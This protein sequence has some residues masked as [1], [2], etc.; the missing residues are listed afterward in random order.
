MKI[1][2]YE[3]K[4]YYDCAEC[5]DAA[6]YVKYGCDIRT[7]FAN[8][9]NF[10]HIKELNDSVLETQIQTEYR[11]D[12][13]LYDYSGLEF[14]EVTPAEK[15]MDFVEDLLESN[16]ILGVYFNNY[17]CNWSKYYKRLNKDHMILLIGIDRHKQ[18]LQVYDKYLSDELK[19]ITWREFSLGAHSFK[20]Y[21]KS[22]DKINIAPQKILK[23]SYALITEVA[24]K[25]AII[26]REQKLRNFFRWIEQIN[27]KTGNLEMIDASTF[28]LSLTYIWWSRLCY[29]DFWQWMKQFEPVDQIIDNLNRCS[30]L[31]LLFRNNI[32]KSLLCQKNVLSMR[33]EKIKQQI[34]DIEVSCLG[35]IKDIVIKL[36]NEGRV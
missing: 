22:N 26:E 34:I 24:D 17:Y 18:L 8:K 28:C 9:F 10:N 20:C 35:H 21:K 16:E 36:E 31:W 32:Y 23:H 2:N 7:R 11:I 1:F 14:V 27:Y 4:P 15:T 5:V 30:E 29:L 25:D 12:K 13:L 33:I 3:T 6:F 19:V